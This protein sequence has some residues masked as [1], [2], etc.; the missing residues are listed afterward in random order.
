M[1][2]LSRILPPRSWCSA[3]RRPFYSDKRRPCRCGSNA[4]TFTVGL[5]DGIK[6]EDRVT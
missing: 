4:R 6:A 2:L 5:A 3:C 1:R